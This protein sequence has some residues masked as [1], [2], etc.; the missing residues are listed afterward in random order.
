MKRESAAPD[1][2]PRELA[3]VRFSALYGD[4]VRELLG[5]AQGFKPSQ[6]PD[7]GLLPRAEGLGCAR[8]GLPVL[9]W[10]QRRQ[11]ERGDQ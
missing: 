3:E 5:Y 7:E 2:L 6:I 11:S 1:D 4:H 9:P 10:K 8:W